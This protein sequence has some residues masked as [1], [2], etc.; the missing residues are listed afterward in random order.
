MRR[1]PA[2]PAAPGLLP[3]VAAVGQGA[4]GQVGADR[5]SDRVLPIAAGS[6]SIGFQG[7]LTLADNGRARDHPPNPLPAV[8]VAR[9]INPDTTKNVRIT[10]RF[11]EAERDA[12]QA[13]AARRGAS[14]SEVIRG[15]LA[16]QLAAAG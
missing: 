11:S 1:Q 10:A 5:P 16:Q 8:M 3:E 7:G 6:G 14:V 15:A 9:R 4:A 2:T 12:L 13:A